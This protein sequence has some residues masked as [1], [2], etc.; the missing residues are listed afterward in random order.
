MTGTQ[1][2]AAYSEIALNDR[3]PVLGVNGSGVDD[4]QALAYINIAARRVMRALA[5]PAKTTFT[6]TDG[7]LT[8]ALS[9]LPI[10]LSKV[11]KVL[12]T[13]GEVPQTDIESTSGWYVLSETLTF[14]ENFTG[15]PTVTVYGIKAPSTITDSGT[16]V[17]SIPEDCHLAVAQLAIIEGVG[18]HR[19]EYAEISQLES[20][21][22]MAINRYRLA[23]TNAYIPQSMFNGDL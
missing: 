4:T 22:L 1:I 14:N 6:F 11:T 10:P 18:S 7:T 17:S 13:N 19:E 15:S 5:I 23:M 16:A 9:S 20:V 8:Y 21:A 12:V 3:F 2:L